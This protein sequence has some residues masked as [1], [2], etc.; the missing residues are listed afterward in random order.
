MKMSSFVDRAVLIVEKMFKSGKMCNQP[1]YSKWEKGWKMQ[2]EGKKNESLFTA[3][4]E[5]KMNLRWNRAIF[6]PL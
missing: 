6:H 4:G 5:K 3:A 2:K 1:Q